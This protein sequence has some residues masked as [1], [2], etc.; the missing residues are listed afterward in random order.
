[1]PSQH[2]GV[3]V[4]AAV[5]A[6]PCHPQRH[7]RHNPLLVATRLRHATVGRAVERLRRPHRPI[8]SRRLDAV[9]VCRVDHSRLQCRLQLRPN[10]VGAH[11]ARQ[12]IPIAATVDE[13]GRPDRQ[14]R[15]APEL[16][17]RLFAFDLAGVL[18]LLLPIVIAADDKARVRELRP[19]G[20]RDRQQVATVER[21][22]DRPP[23]RS[24]HAGARC[25]PLDDGDHVVGVRLAEAVVAP[26]HGDA[27]AEALV[28]AVFA[29]LG[30]DRLQP[31]QVA[32][33]VAER[34]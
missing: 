9:V 33:R 6:H 26:R 31:P 10:R 22:G 2:K 5:N 28:G 23:H 21:H 24:V 3:A 7:P 4:V 13:A 20:L 34:H 11:L 15:D 16:A 12:I 17:C 32:C 27:L 19:Q 25:E 14:H 29:L 1:M 30:K 18:R 8:V